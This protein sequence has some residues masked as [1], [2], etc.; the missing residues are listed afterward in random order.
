MKIELFPL[1]KAVV[2]GKEI[3]LGMKQAAVEAVIG[4]GRHSGNRFYYFNSE[5]AIDYDAEKCVEFIEYLGGPDGRLQPEIYGVS[6]FAVSADELAVLLME[7]NAGEIDDSEGGY[8]LAFLNIS[9]GVY[10]E[11]IPQNVEEMIEEMN[12]DGIDTK[13]NEMVDEEK[14]RAEHWSTIGMGR[15]EYYKK[16]F[17]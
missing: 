2:N 13:N 4:I 17:L 16:Y 5:M 9:V 10:R 7:K 11:S 6:A 8:S 15:K 12:A 1:D 3:L 14:R